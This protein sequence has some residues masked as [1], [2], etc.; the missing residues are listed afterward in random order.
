MEGQGIAHQ[1]I[2]FLF[3]SLCDD[4]SEVLVNA[5]VFARFGL[6]NVLSRSWWDASYAMV[7]F[8]PFILITYTCSFGVRNAMCINHKAN[9]YLSFTHYKLKIGGVPLLVEQPFHFSRIS[10]ACIFCSYYDAIRSFLRLRNGQRVLILDI[11]MQSQ[12]REPVV[13]WHQVKRS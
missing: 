12:R 11:C 8:A 6:S 7:H 10:L 1:G 9:F 3:A 13:L 4:V 5:S 2:S